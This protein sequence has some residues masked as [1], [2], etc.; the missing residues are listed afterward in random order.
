ME[1]TGIFLPLRQQ[2]LARA[3]RIHNHQI[4]PAG[5]RL[6][7]GFR[8]GAGG[9]RRAEAAALQVADQHADP[10]ADRLIGHQQ[11]RL[12]RPP[13]KD[14]LAPRRGAEIHQPIDPIGNRQQGRSRKHRGKI[15]TIER[16]HLMQG[17]LAGSPIG[18][19]VGGQIEPIDPDRL[20]RQGRQGREGKRIGAIG[21]PQQTGRKPLVLAEAL[22]KGRAIG[23]LPK[24]AIG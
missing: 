9:D 6:G 15:Q 13:G 12:Q 24:Q 2:G 8:V 20:H 17:M 23:R 18:R 19:L 21:Q 22:D 3:G 7:Q 4:R 16:P 14:T 1:T 10:F 5:N 11:R